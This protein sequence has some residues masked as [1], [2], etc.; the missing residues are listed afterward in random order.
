VEKRPT[1]LPRRPEDTSRHED[2][3]AWLALSTSGWGG[4]TAAPAKHAPCGAA[5]KRGPTPAEVSF[6]A[7]R[8]CLPAGAIM[9]AGSGA[10]G[11]RVGAGTTARL[12][13][14]HARGQ[15]AHRSAALAV[16]AAL[17]PVRQA[18]A[19]A[20]EPPCTLE[21]AT[22]CGNGTALSVEYAS[23]SRIARAAGAAAET[24]PALVERGACATARSPDRAPAEAREP[25]QDAR[26]HPDHRH[27]CSRY[28]APA[29]S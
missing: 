21:G 22:V 19:T 6:A 12:A 23:R 17:L 7:A 20:A 27:A 5:V 14:A 29:R 15:V 18:R 16:V 10:T 1:E 4:T 3:V 2:L 13:A 24:A 9:A 11:G 25:D 8:A 26:D 28:A